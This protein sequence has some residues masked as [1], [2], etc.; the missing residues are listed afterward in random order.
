MSQTDNKNM[1]QLLAEANNAGSLTDEA[2]TVINT[3]TDLG[4]ELQ[5]GMGINVDDVM[6]DQVVL[7]GFLIDDSS[8]IRFRSNA[9][10]VRNGHNVVL[11]AVCASKQGDGILAHN[12]YL[13]G[14]VLYPWTQV[15]QVPKMDSSNYNPS[16]GTPLYDQSI[17]FL[18]T[19]AAKTE[20]FAKSGLSTRSITLIM[21]DGDDCGSRKSPDDVRKVV[22]SMLKT[23]NHIIAAM[24]IDDGSTDFNQVFT[25]MGIR[26]EWIFTPG[27]NVS[28][29]RKA[30]EL[31]SKS[32][33]RAS[34][35]AASFSQA[36][37]GAFG[38]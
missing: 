20:Q 29:I 25:E 36:A 3:I 38:G 26:P 15:D 13:N 23:E 21:T 34:Q 37:A 12:R 7:L 8:S 27:N 18:A 6:A 22:E 16:G 5:E 17:V 33:V 11:D 24:G 19:V 2:L 10:N 9:E 31:F 1:K 14:V 30:F 35:S 32:A 4:A 28:E